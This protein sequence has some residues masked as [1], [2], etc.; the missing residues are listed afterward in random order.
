M[1]I[2]L[3]NIVVISECRLSHSQLFEASQ[4]I[5]RNGI[6]R[7][8]EWKDLILLQVNISGK[9]YSEGVSF[10]HGAAETNLRLWV[11]FLALLSG[12]GIRHC[13]GLWYRSQ[14]QLGCGVTVAVA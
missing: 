5:P 7:Y 2:S 9:S 10:S 1:E 3:L 8:L 13:C 14:T 11:R 4:I 12:L 6:Y